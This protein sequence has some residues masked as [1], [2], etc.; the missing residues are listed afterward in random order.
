MNTEYETKTELQ[1]TLLA[2]LKESGFQV[3]ERI[4]VRTLE[5]V[6]VVVKEKMNASELISAVC[7]LEQFRGELEEQLMSRCERCTGCESECAYGALDFAVDISLP[8]ELRELAGISPHA[9]VHVESFGDGEITFSA[10]R[11]E[12]GLWDIPPAIMSEYLARGICP[13][14]LEALMNSGKT[15]YGE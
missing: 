6:V 2:A 11:D 9:P 12:P 8:Q 7:Q 4:E 1:K 5:S 10:N 3:G 13:A 14:S 15:V